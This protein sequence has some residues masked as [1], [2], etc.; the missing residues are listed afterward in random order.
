MIHFPVKIK[1]L[2][3]WPPLFLAPMTGL[4]HS[5]LRMLLL[6]FGGVGLLSTEMLSARRLASENEAISPYLVKTAA[7]RPLSYQLLVTDSSDVPPA[8]EALHRFGADAVDINLGCPAPN[9]N[10]AG[11]GS[12]LMDRPGKAREIVSTARKRTDLPLTAKIRLGR[13]LDREPLHDFCRMLEAEG[14]DLLTVHARLQGESFSRRPRWDWIAE[15]KQ[16]LSIPVIANGAIFSVADARDCL[17]ISGADG[18]MI[19]RAAPERP[20]IFAAIARELYGMKCPPPEINLPHIYLNMIQGLTAH[21]RPERRLGR[22][23]EFTHYFA[24]NYTFGHYLASAV[25][26]SASINEARARAVEFFHNNEPAAGISLPATP[27]AAYRF[28]APPD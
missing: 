14:V 8:M 22:L 9:V 6:S 23:K 16:R 10:R 24:R 4:T 27:P 2:H 17:R 28:T 15:I 1:Y 12:C 20:W 25:Q 7:E 5:S 21:F 18:L 3:I 26:A 11:G 19:G 13:S